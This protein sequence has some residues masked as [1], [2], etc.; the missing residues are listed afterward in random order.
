MG[1]TTD[2]HLVNR[3]HRLAKRTERSYAA[4]E[5]RPLGGYLA[6]MA[7]FGVYTAAWITA[8]RQRGRPLPE[9][10]EPWDVV[11]TSV[12]T[13]RL[14]RLLSKAAVTSPLRAPFTTFVGPQG[15]AEL[16]EEARPEDGKDTVGELVTCPFCM[17]VWVA[18]TLTASRLL[19][20]R[21]TRTA[22]SALAALAGA[23]ALQLAYSALMG[24]ADDSG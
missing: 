1:A 18:S 2:S 3:L 17:S 10:P 9:R 16:H 23:D 14:S 12:A 5:D 7:G 22:M 8:V 20:P 11:L 6:A 13:F 15:P 24:K 19:W 4:G 21:G